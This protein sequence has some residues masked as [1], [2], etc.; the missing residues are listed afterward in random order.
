[1]PLLYMVQLCS[2]KGDVLENT[3]SID[4]TERRHPGEY[5]AL[6]SASLLWLQ[7]RFCQRFSGCP[8][9]KRNCEQLRNSGTAPE[10]PTPSHVLHAR[11][12]RASL[13]RCRMAAAFNEIG[14]TE[15]TS[16]GF[17]KAHLSVAHAMENAI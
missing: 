13:V 9:L 1:M 2:V 3:Q 5:E 7:S 10:Q 4:S 15:R 16:E 8:G 6:M 11:F 12:S 14:L 17:H